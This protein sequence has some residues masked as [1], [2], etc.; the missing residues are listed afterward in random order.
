MKKE[1]FVIIDSFALIFR[2]YYAYPPTLSTKDGQLTNA[3]YG[4]ST[5]L[6]EVLKKFEPDYLVAVYDSASP[7]IRS[8]EF[9]TYKANRKE[10]EPD[11]ISQIHLVRK[12]IES[13]EIP[14]LNVE[15]YEA[16]DIIAT[17]CNTYREHDIQNIVV[18]GDQDLFQ[19][20]NDKTSVYLAGRTFSKS[21]LYDR[22]GVIEKLMVTPEQIPDYKGLCGDPSDNIPGVAGIG[23]KSSVDLLSKYKTIE[24]LYEH[25]EEVENKYKNKLM[26][27][28]E[29]AI[30]SK[31]L[32]TVVHDVPL[33]FDLKKAEFK[34]FPVAKVLET[35]D[36]FEFKSIKKRIE[37]L[38]EKMV[39]LNE[40]ENLDL[41]SSVPIEDTIKEKK[42]EINDLK[43]GDLFI[44][45]D[46]KNPDVS[47][48]K[49]EIEK[50]FISD[51]GEVAYTI[52]N[53]DIEELIKKIIKDE[54]RLIGINLKDFFHAVINKGI[55]LDF[56]KVKFEDLGFCTAILSLGEIGHSISDLSK[57]TGIEFGSSIISLV[58]NL[59]KTHE[60]CKEKFNEDKKL[61]EVYELEKEVLGVVI[62]MEQEGIRFDSDRCSEA[63]EI[64]QKGREE[65]QKKIYSYSDY[66][67]NINSPKQVG[68]VL[69][70]KL[71][72]PQ[73]RKTKGGAFSTNEKALRSI[74]EAHPIVQEILNYR[75]VD[76]LLSTYIKALPEYVDSDGKIH[77]TFDQ[78]GA[79]SGRFSSK[80]PNMQ[81]IPASTAFDVNI[82][83]LF[84][85]DK[86]SIFLAFDYSQQELRI[87][88][89][90]ANEELMIESFNKGEDIHAITAANLFGKDISEVTKAERATGKT[91]NFSVI[92]GVSSFGLS[93]NLKIGRAEAQALINNYYQKYKKIS[94]YFEKKRDEVHLKKFGET[95]LGRKRVNPMKN[96]SQWFIKNAVE[97]ELLN[98]AVQGSAADLMKLA[99]VEINK[100]I[101]KY[102]AKL[103]L[104]IHDEFLFEFNEPKNQKLLDEFKKEII[105]SMEGV[106]NI[107]VSYKVDVK[108]GTVW[109][110]ME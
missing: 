53:K 33:S 65:I 106:K 54:I 72:L 42:I 5:L 27:N 105:Q 41:F 91:I 31:Q 94:E 56:S 29:I 46:L 52:S 49:Y 51:G 59:S 43:K 100:I 104:Q 101:K 86:D 45:F 102:P 81:N 24:N 4:F 69:F 79:V 74:I 84:I 26:N 107:G 22:D 19:L 80:D 55:K 83:D 57:F 3:V 75:E 92:Y 7:T 73:Q 110:K 82:R 88:A 40:E 90:L 17:L 77:A 44:A 98:F 60:K 47:P 71:G 38:A 10:Q 108:S 8:T 96:S 32:A 11:L 39:F 6:L 87:L 78:L 2:A 37:E 18:T 16:D 99:M 9:A 34:A 76:K 25:I 63:L 95:I 66:E 58:V 35:M 103:L 20:I 21:K 15:G 23:S 14:V 62:E 85:A 13:F 1:N 67:F 93:E 70:D 12:L 89:A 48:I 64:L 61:F 68:E 109:G 50:I 28:Y 97:R 30:K 36:G